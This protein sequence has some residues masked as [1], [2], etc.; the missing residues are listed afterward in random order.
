L[1]I[2]SIYNYVLVQYLGCIGYKQLIPLGAIVE[3]KR[4]HIVNKLLLTYSF[5]I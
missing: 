2:Y 3:K 1:L 4:Q 5:I